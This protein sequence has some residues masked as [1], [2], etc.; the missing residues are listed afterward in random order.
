[1]RIAQRIL[2]LMEHNKT[3]LEPDL[4]NGVWGYMQRANEFEE[5]MRMLLRTKRIGMDMVNE[6]TL[7]TFKGGK[8][9][10]K[11]ISISG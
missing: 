2:E 8:K 11:K 6:G 9:Y 1:M 4:L 3:M 5:V 7:Y 10:G